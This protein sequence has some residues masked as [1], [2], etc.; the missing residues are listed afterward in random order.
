LNRWRNLRADWRFT[1]GVFFLAV[2]LQTAA[3][4]Q[5]TA[6]TPLYLREVI[7]LPPEQVPFWTGALAALSLGL[8][9]PMAPWWGVLADRYSHKLFIVRSMAVDAIGYS[10]ASVAGELWHVVALRMV[11]GFSFGNVGIIFATQSLVTPERRVGTAIGIIQA[12]MPIGMSL[13]PLLGGF[14]VEQVGLRGLFTVNAIVSV[15]AFV[16]VVI[17]V[18]EPDVHGLDTV[19]RFVLGAPAIRWNFVI[20]FLLSYGMMSIDPFIPIL[21]ERVYDGPDLPRVIGTVLA[22]YGISTGFA[23][24]LVARLGERFGATRW[25][26]MTTP[27]LAISVLAMALAD[28]LAIVIALQLLRALPQSGIQAVLYTHLAHEVPRELRASVMSLS[29]LPRNVAGFLAPLTAAIVSSLSLG[30]VFIVGGLAYLAACAATFPLRR[31][32]GTL[33]ETVATPGS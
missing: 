21:I 30:L 4:G 17:C 14:V 27:V 18:R 24:P 8:A 33:R 20:W 13:G 28:S 25:L 23:T 2:L 7:K 6:F 26:A 10:I 9:I 12:A 11:L 3:F 5:L 15:T 32:T 22:L 16:L 31:A 1:A 19:S 29:P